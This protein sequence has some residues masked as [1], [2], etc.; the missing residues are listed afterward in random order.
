M[1]IVLRKCPLEDGWPILRSFAIR[2]QYI[3]GVSNYIPFGSLK[4]SPG[5]AIR[6][7][8]VIHPHNGPE[9]EARAR[10]LSEVR[11]PGGR[12]SKAGPDGVFYCTVKASSKL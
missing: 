12:A 10:A 9:L 8:K 1:L 4:D 6:T 11:S 7:G 5:L 3:G 2:G